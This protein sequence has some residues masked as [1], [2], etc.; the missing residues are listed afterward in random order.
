[1]YDAC[2]QDDVDMRSEVFA[3]HILFKLELSNSFITIDTK[4]LKNFDPSCS[5]VA[6]LPC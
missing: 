4:C 6:I 5:Q 1:M 3:A 2:G